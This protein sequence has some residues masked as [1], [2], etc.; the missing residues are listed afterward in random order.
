MESQ[1]PTPKSVRPPLPGDVDAE[2]RAACAWIVTHP[3]P[4]HERWDTSI[5]KPALDYRA[6]KYAEAGPVSVVPVLA[7]RHSARSNLPSKEASNLD[8]LPDSTKYSYRPNVLA[9]DLFKP[10]DVGTKTARSRVEQ[11]MAPEAP[12]PAT[13]TATATTSSRQRSGSH[14]HSHSA[15]TQPNVARKESG[16]KKRTSTRSDSIGTSGSTPHTD[17][18]EYPWSA[19]TAMTSAVMTPS[20]SKRASSQAINTGVEGGIAPK[21]KADVVNAEWMRLELE[22]HF[23]TQE[24][25]KERKEQQDEPVLCSATYIPSGA[26]PR[27][28]RDFSHVPARKP[29]PSRTSS[30]QPGPASRPETSQNTRGRGSSTHRGRTEVADHEDRGRSPPRSYSRIGRASRAASRAASVAATRAGSIANEIFLHMDRR[31]TQ[32]A[33]PPTEARRSH[34]KAHSTNFSRGPARPPSRARSISRHVKEYFRPGSSMSMRKDSLDS[35]RSNT[36][37]SEKPSE[38]GRGWQLLHRGRSTFDLTRPGSSASRATTAEPQSP[39]YAKPAVDLNR[40]LPPLPSLDKW[41]GAQ[42]NLEKTRPKSPGSTLNR[43]L[44]KMDLSKNPHVARMAARNPRSQ[45]LDSGAPRAS[46]PNLQSQSWRPAT[47]DTRRREQTDEVSRHR[48]HAGN[49][50]DNLQ[51]PMP[52]LQR[53]PRPPSHGIVPASNRNGFVDP[54]SAASSPRFSPAL[55]RVDPD[56]ATIN[57]AHTRDSYFRSRPRHRDESQ[58]FSSHSHQRSPTVDEKTRR[59]WWPGNLKRSP[60]QAGRMDSVIRPS[61]GMPMA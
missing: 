31:P 4:S 61:S 2:L 7:K 18:T 57:S 30:I 6:I 28:S 15:S 27:Y 32:P 1:P 36:A 59:K 9:E 17:S 5:S 13:A 38:R 22:K 60:S 11:L 37:P 50:R 19:S 16:E 41:E 14:S 34:S 21:S 23:R 56:A 8:L 55:H 52:Q 39:R 43:A 29:V 3:K 44:S 26:S 42:T 25:V 12:R 24:K 47:S 46:A 10:A 54:D 58:Q 51:Q 49:S 35:G 53:V 45:P 40:E 33:Q 48:H 20:R